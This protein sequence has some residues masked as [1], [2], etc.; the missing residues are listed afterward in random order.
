LDAA[1]VIEKFRAVTETVLARDEQQRIVDR[2]M[3]FNQALSTAALD[4]AIAIKGT[5]K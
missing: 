2:V 4:D 5:S 3:E 1:A